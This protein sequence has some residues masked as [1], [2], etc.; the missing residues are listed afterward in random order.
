MLISLAVH[1]QLPLLQL[2]RARSDDRQS[3]VQMGTAFG[4]QHEYVPFPVVYSFQVRNSKDDI[5]HNIKSENTVTGQRDDVCVVQHYTDASLSMSASCYPQITAVVS[6]MCATLSSRCT[7]VCCAVRRRHQYY[8][9]NIVFPLFMITSGT[10]ESHCD[11]S[12][13]V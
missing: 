3:K 5:V 12:C 1:H 13:F 4:P 8:F 7:H 10:A 9:W 11:M 6:G 2:V